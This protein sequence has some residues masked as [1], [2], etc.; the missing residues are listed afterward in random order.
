MLWMSLVFVNK[1]ILRQLAIWIK[2]SFCFRIQFLSK[3]A[4]FYL[5]HFLE[6][7]KRSSKTQNLLQFLFSGYSRVS[8]NTSTDWDIMW[9]HDYP[10]TKVRKICL[11][12]SVILVLTNKVLFVYVIKYQLDIEA[13]PTSIMH[14]LAFRY[15]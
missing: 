5:L 13:L 10:F 12:L 14:H 8:Y 7:E 6:I 4:W 11:S 15:S 3:S 2:F 9:A 1:G